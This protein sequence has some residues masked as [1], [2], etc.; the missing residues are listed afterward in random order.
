MM[1]S[2]AK[3]CSANDLRKSVECHQYQYMKRDDMHTTQADMRSAVDSGNVLDAY[4][5]LVE[6]AL[7]NVATPE[8]HLAAARYGLLCGLRCRFPGIGRAY[9][10]RI[11]PRVRQAAL[12]FSCGSSFSIRKN[13]G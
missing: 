8:L 5:V 10:A 2:F 6:Q 4:R 3:Q 11:P 7:S 1:S 9:R 13:A 12:G